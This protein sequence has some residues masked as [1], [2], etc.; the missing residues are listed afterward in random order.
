MGVVSTSAPGG[1]VGTGIAML[2]HVS[3]RQH[4]AASEAR[5]MATQMP[6][7]MP[8]EFERFRS[9]RGSCADEASVT[10]LVKIHAAGI[11]VIRQDGNGQD[12]L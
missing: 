10:T 6:K 12:G 7:S 8:L 9:G 11:D 4:K 5:H 3:S 1:I 2:A